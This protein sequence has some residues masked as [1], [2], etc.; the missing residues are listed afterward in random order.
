M[1]GTHTQ[2]R[3]RCAGCDII[4]MNDRFS[5]RRLASILFAVVNRNL[6]NHPREGDR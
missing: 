4:H 2:R 1:E 6:A 5:T 3:L